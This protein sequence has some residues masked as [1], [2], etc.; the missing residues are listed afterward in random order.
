M[1]YS[2]L[3]H[4]Q[5]SMANKAD[6][7]EL[8]LACADVCKALDRGIKGRKLDDLNQPVFEAIGQLTT[9]VEPVMDTLGHSLTTLS[10]AGPWRR[11]KGR[12][13]NRV[14]GM[15]SPD[16]PMRRAI[17]KRSGPGNRTSVGS[18]RSLTCVLSPLR[19]CGHR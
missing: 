13:S 17:R 3:T 18:F 7:V 8:G 12:L 16:L 15:R 14:S 9:W 4:N 5:D 10:I 11:S 2:R 1:S 19:V 6:Y